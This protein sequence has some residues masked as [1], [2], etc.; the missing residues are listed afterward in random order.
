MQ[1]TIEIKDSMTERERTL[2]KTWSKKIVLGRHR[3]MYLEI[4]LTTWTV[5][6]MRLKLCGLFYV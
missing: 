1:G 5:A 4:L 3:K 2:I 6:E